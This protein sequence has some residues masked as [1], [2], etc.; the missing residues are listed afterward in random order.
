[1]TFGI[2]IYSLAGLLIVVLLCRGG[3]RGGA[4]GAMA[5]PP[6][7]GGGAKG[8][9]GGAKG[10]C[11]ILTKMTLEN[12]S[13]VPQICSGT[14]RIAPRALSFQNFLGGVPPNPPTGNIGG[15][16]L[17]QLCCQYS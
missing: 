2:Y 11:M 14:L 12:M 6:L 16:P 8:G 4:K 3:S 5:P 13:D 10:R 17:H 9:G 15:E 7:E 1:M